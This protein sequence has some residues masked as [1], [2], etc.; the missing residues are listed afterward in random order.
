[1]LH[2]H[3]DVKEKVD[4]FPVDRGRV[5]GMAGWGDTE[6]FVERGKCPKRGDSLGEFRAF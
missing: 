4:S 1:M 3:L 6:M 5:R 2:L